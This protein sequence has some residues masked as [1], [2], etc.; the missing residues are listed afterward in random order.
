MYSEAGEEDQS[1]T[2]SAH[3]CR[4]FSLTEIQSA[5][6]D[7]A[8]EL[9]IGKGAFG[10]VYMGQISREKAC[11]AVA[12]KRQDSM[13]N[14]G[15][16]EFR[17]E[18]EMLSKLR[19]SHLVSLVGYC[20]DS[21]EMILVYEYMPNGTLY[22]HLHKA[23]T[24]LNW[25]QRMKIAIGAAR[26]L[27]YLHTGVGTQHGVVHR[28]VKTSNILLDNNLEA[29][30]SDFG[31]SK[32]GP[33]NHSTS[34][35]TG[36]VKG[37]FGY[38][39]PDYF[40]TRKLTTKVD[41]YAF[42]VVLFELL[43]GRLAVDELY[44]EEECSLVVWAKKSVKERKIDQMV[45][46]N[47]KGTIHPKCARGFAQIANRCVHSVPKERPTM[48]EVV[49]SLQ[50]LQVQEKKYDYSLRS[51]G[52]TG[53]PSRIPE[54]LVSSTKLYIPDFLVSSTK[55]YTGAKVVIHPLLN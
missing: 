3:P 44:G 43:S 1:S 22:H 15:E 36:S 31:L 25:V 39:D 54:F 10:K 11:R 42:G 38:L 34:Y 8:D 41:V 35:V 29:M 30:I 24:P 16:P 48:S 45:D 7:F 52:K 47:I 32:I 17:S 28:D 2:T 55:L 18:I 50:A 12:I 13:S 14:Q 49:A 9:V 21:K 23:H 19:H 4:L 46:P 33:T 51:R 26:G 27:D 53:I 20:D 6:K 37:T 5:T 40:Y